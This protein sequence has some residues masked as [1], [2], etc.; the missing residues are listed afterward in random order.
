MEPDRD[1]SLR[2]FST[3]VALSCR[4]PE[5]SPSDG[6]LSR[7]LLVLLAGARYFL[8]RHMLLAGRKAARSSCRPGG[9]V[10]ICS[11]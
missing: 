4:L 5:E 2:S 10:I 3:R 1:H 11:L 9:V 6:A 8:N 7:F